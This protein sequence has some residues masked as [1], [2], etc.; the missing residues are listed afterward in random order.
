MSEEHVGPY[1][2][3]RC[4]WCKKRKSGPAGIAGYQRREIYA[5]VGPW[6]DACEEHA[7]IPYE[8]PKQFQREENHE[9]NKVEP[10]PV[11]TV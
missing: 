3:D 8:Q 11:G 9:S 1:D 4:H 10:S 2:N 5:T 6:L 7:K